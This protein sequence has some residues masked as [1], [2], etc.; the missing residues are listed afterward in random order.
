MGQACWLRDEQDGCQRAALLMANGEMML[1]CAAA[2]YGSALRT[3]SVDT[4]KRCRRTLGYE[5]L[6]ALRAALDAHRIKEQE[7]IA[8]PPNPGKPSGPSPGYR[9]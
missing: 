9:R 7:V 2:A 5:Q 4:A 6:W 1:W 8:R 3:T